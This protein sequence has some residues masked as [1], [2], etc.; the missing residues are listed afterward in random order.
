MQCHGKAR[1]NLFHLHSA[2]SA[3]L[4]LPRPQVSSL[5]PQMITE[6]VW[7]QWWSPHEF[8]W[9]PAQKEM[10]KMP[11]PLTYVH[12]AIFL[13]L[14]SYIFCPVISGVSPPSPSRLFAKPLYPLFRQMP[15]NGTLPIFSCSVDEIVGSRYGQCLK[16]L[17][18][19]GMELCPPAR[20]ALSVEKMLAPPV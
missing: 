13:C 8:H 1:I 6:R 20:S 15:W 2:L 4:N 12:Q 17:R 11:K 10:T 19:V 14:Y 7:T 3:W 18:V 16:F 9:L 5:F